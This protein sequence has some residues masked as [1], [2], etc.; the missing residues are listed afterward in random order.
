[1]KILSMQATFGKLDGQSLTLKPGLNII[2]APNEWGKSTWCAF[3]MDMLYGVDSRERTTG[4]A[5]A[6]KE[7]FF[8]W[9]GKPMSG[10]MEIEYNGKKITLERTSKGRVP[11]GQFRAYETDTGLPVSGLTADNCG[12]ILLG[13][14]RNVFARAGFIRLTQMPVTDDAALRRRLNELVT[15]GDESGTCDA[16]E[17]K[18]KD[19]KNRCRHNKTGLLPQTEQQRFDLTQRL[20]AMDEAKH[21][22][23][24]IRQRCAE[25]DERIEK[26]ENHEKTLAYEASL[27]DTRRVEQAE[28]AAQEAEKTFENLLEKTRDLPDRE[29]C[30]RKLRA[31]EDLQEQWNLFRDAEQAHMPMP[32]MPFAGLDGEQAILQA[33][34]DTADHEKYKR[35]PTPLF[36]IGAIL[37][38][39]AAAIVLHANWY[40]I[41]PPA[42][43]AIV[44][45]IFYQR[46]RKTRRATLRR[47]ARRYG[48]WEPS[49]WLPEARQYAD[50][51]EAYRKDAE[52]Y[53]N[54]KSEL[55]H[56]T[57]ELAGQETLTDAARRFSESLAL[58]GQAQQ[59]QQAAATA[60]S[61]A[62]ELKAMHRPVLAPT[63]PDSL[64]LSREQTQSALF[65]ARRDRQNLQEM[66]GRCQE[67]LAGLGER[68]ALTRL[69]DR[70]NERIAKLEDTYA[71]LEIAQETMAEASAELQRRFAPRIAESA[72]EIFSALT[73]G[74]YD[75]LI[76]EQDLS[77]CTRAQQEDTLRQSLWR[78]DGTVDQMYLALRLS[79]A[80]ELTPGSPLILDDALVRFDDERLKR[81]LALLGEMG[82]KKQILLF[83]CQ[84]REQ[85]SMQSI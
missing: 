23:E 56:A 18:I 9:S 1:M 37:C 49:R 15:T 21:Q 78:S 26:L 8:P 34:Q 35:K 38:L 80:G 52:D 44:L 22:S 82:K 74:R 4:K 17:Q 19:L 58:Y 32:P 69:L 6:D 14:E 70:T 83:T 20:A 27:A 73:G 45:F 55:E 60:V 30:E 7:R 16:L 28:A 43:A 3:L 24:T 13:V 64:T 2:E 25:L 47:L 84:S 33:Q 75:K 76:L 11:F 12:Q 57:R 65:E 85:S 66:S 41:V 81:V 10:Q 68:D 42:V 67:R 36:L 46:G 40:F 48:D 62:A 51:C 72:Q 79:I 63:E 39:L 5:L 53:D 31:I 71:A 61:H 29:D 54:R 59:A 77:V 50:K